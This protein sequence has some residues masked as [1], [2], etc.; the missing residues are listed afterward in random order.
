M[1]SFTVSC[2]SLP[3]PLRVDDKRVKALTTTIQSFVFSDESNPSAI[4]SKL[5]ILASSNTRKHF[6]YAALLI[7]TEVLNEI[8]NGARTWNTENTSKI[9]IILYYMDSSYLLLPSFA[10]MPLL[11]YLLEKPK[12][13]NKDIVVVLM[14]LCPALL[15]R[16]AKEGDE[17]TCPIFSIFSQEDVDFDI[18]YGAICLHKTTARFV[19]IP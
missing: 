13:F 6:A 12:L 11:H 2:P 3:N 9:L 7:I 10:N 18:V 15:I 5:K 1:M 8:E 19:S 4:S 17:S 14:K 16:G